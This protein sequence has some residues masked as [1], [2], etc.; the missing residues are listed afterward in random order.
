[1]TFDQAYYRLY[2]YDPRTAVTTKREMWARAR[3]IAAYSRHAGLK[4]A[5]ILDA[6]C[7]TGM[8]RAA[9]GRCLPRASYTGLET[10]DYLCRRYGWQQ[11]TIESYRTASPFDLVVCYD[12]L[13]YL[14]AAVAARALANLARVCSGILYFTALTRL[15]WL[16]NC[17]R[18]RTD[19]NV[20]L[21]SARW[22]RERLRRGFREIGA[23]FWLRRHA[24]VTVWELESA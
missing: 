11:G 1:M 13:Q 17:D 15:D 22:Y 6:G 12:V 4:V 18:G 21:R 19:S 9:L 3:L 23:G 24:P 2:Y 20:H 16:R 7:G 10:S 5:R 8:M 14:D